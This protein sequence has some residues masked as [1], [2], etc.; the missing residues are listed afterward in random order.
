VR[1]PARVFINVVR[2]SKRRT[3]LVAAIVEHTWA[4]VATTPFDT[5]E[6]MDSDAAWMA[7]NY[8]R[9]LGQLG[10][11][12]VASV[13]R[14]VGSRVLGEQLC[15]LYAVIEYVGKTSPNKR[16]KPW[17]DALVR[18]LKKLISSEGFLV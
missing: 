15:A 14:H 17:R 12:G 7:R 18:S 11:S 2:A 6:D 13:A 3:P 8:G 9:M 16:G 4:L 1:P 10:P 5:I